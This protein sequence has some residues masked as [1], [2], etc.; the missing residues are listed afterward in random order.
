MHSPRSALANKQVLIC[1]ASITDTLD[2]FV[3]LSM[4]PRCYVTH[5]V[6]VAA[7]TGLLVATDFRTL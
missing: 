5:R 7:A 1:N 6:G 4:P 3:G 2:T